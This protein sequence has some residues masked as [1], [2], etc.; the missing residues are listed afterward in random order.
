VCGNYVSSP[1][2]LPGVKP[3]QYVDTDIQFCGFPAKC[4]KITNII[5]ANICSF[6][7]RKCET[8]FVFFLFLLS[9]VF[10]LKVVAR[11]VRIR[12]KNFIKTSLL[13]LEKK[14]VICYNKLNN[15][16]VWKGA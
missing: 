12:A 6:V 7:K 11:S 16:K 14:C 2:A 4:D 10:E 3:A 9:S 13:V 1:Q 8:F 15:D 5:I